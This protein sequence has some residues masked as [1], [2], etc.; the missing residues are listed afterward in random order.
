MHSG[1]SFDFF[2][3]LLI[4]MYC[5]GK[6]LRSIMT[7][8]NVKRNLSERKIKLRFYF[9]DK[10]KCHHETLEKLAR[11]NERNKEFNGNLCFDLFSMKNF[12]RRKA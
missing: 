5:L 3:V 11:A 6:R 4:P 2:E 12:V 7:F 9:K 8:K 10:K 1:N